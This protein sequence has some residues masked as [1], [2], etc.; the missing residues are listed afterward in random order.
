M[1]RTAEVRLVDFGSL[2]ALIHICVGPMFV[3]GF[4]V[5]DQ[6]EGKVWIAPPSREIVR[7]GRKE[8]Y[9]IVRWANKEAK[10]E[11]DK[12]ALEMYAQARKDMNAIS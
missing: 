2:K 7:E 3:R 12:W 11:F 1:E 4:K 6:G 10:E 8:Y 5:I 9:D